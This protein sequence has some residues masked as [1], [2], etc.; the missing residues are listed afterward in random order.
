[1][2]WFGNNRWKS[3]PCAP[4]ERGIGPA[5]SRPIPG[6][7]R[8]RVYSS[9]Y[10]EYAH[11]RDKNRLPVAEFRKT[12]VSLRVCPPQQRRLS[13]FRRAKRRRDRVPAKKYQG[14]A[15]TETTASESTSKAAASSGN[16]GTT[17]T[18]RKPDSR[19]YLK[20]CRWPRSA[21]REGSH[22][23]LRAFWQLSADTPRIL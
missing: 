9:L 3:A 6:G 17:C 14:Y 8:C 22:E 23:S 13:L 11:W 10:I 7:W 19:R 12:C 16:S 15:F 18:H 21:G 5:G 2:P 1:M 4:R 20:P